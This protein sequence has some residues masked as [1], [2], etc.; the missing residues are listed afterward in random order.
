LWEGRSCNGFN[1]EGT[2]RGVIFYGEKGTMEVPGGDAYKV[3]DLG[4]KLVKDVKTD[5]EEATRTNTMGMGEKLDSIVLS[6]FVESIRGVEKQT[7]PISEGHKSTLLPQLGNISQRVGRTLT[8]NPL[9]GHIL[10]D[11]EAMKLWK[12][13]YQ[14]GWEMV[15]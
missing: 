6:N 12:R 10:N 9:N 11:K 13:E 8:C 2:G 15:L 7:A 3:Y 1:S 4:N 5:L 14:K